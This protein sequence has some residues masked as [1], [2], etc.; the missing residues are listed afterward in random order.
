MAGN[1]ATIASTRHRT[2]ES[3]KLSHDAVETVA[4]RHLRFREVRLRYGKWSDLLLFWQV[5]LWNY[6]QCPCIETTRI[7][8]KY[9]IPLLR[10]IVSR[11][12]L[13]IYARTLSRLSSVTVGEWLWP[14]LRVTPKRILL[15]RLQL[16]TKRHNTSLTRI[17]T[18]NWQAKHTHVPYPI[19]RNSVAIEERF[20]S[21]DDAVGQQKLRWDDMT[22]EL[23]QEIGRR[24]RTSKKQSFL[25]IVLQRGLGMR[26]PQHNE[27]RIRSRCSRCLRLCLV[28]TPA[29][30]CSVA[31]L[32][33]NDPALV[34]YGAPAHSDRTVFTMVRKVD[35]PSVSG[36]LPNYI[37]KW[38][39]DQ[40]YVASQH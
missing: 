16:S 33:I 23:V 14:P 30:L 3:P 13:N 39:S 40:F 11:T 25:S 18:P 8:V 1:L 22:I 7:S 21:V 32:I 2:R 34:I 4:R 27:H 15:S 38:Q 24:T 29:A 19:A 20:L 31:K 9:F 17:S 10:I 36:W 28:F 6:S 37:R 5:D 35:L 12:R 26:Y